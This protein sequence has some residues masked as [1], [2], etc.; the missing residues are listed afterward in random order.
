[1]IEDDIKYLWAAKRIMADDIIDPK[2]FADSVIE[3]IDLRYDDAWI[4]EAT[5]KK[6][7]RPIGVIFGLY[8]GPIEIIGDIMWFPWASKRNVIEGI[9]KF[10]NE[11]RKNKLLVGWCNQKDKNLFV[12][13]ARH[14]ILKRIGTLD[15]IYENEPAAMFQSR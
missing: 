7:F 14:G 5:T 8:A 6:G 4:I 12:H 13:V 11:E 10:F 15:G 1:M 9:V 3:E 2:E